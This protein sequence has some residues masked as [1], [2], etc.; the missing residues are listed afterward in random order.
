[1]FTFWGLKVSNKFKRKC[2]KT[3]QYLKKIPGLVSLSISQLAP[4]STI[5]EHT[6]DT[7]AIVRC[8]LGIEVPASLPDCGLGVNG[9][10]RS[11][12]EGK[13]IVF[14]DAY[15]HTAWNNTGKRRIIIIADIIKPEFMDRKNIACAFILTRH[16][17]YIY[18]RVKLIAK[19][20]VF[21]K[22]LLFG[23]FLSL[24]YVFKPVYNLFR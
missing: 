15:K 5:A 13:W 8:H 20:P 10:Q 18:H 23:F 6:G 17:S 21:L 22:T 11:W 12:A 9:E 7:N 4:N 14:N 2:P 24:I 16:V 1:M 3:M 19:M